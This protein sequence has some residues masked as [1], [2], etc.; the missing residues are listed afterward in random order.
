MCNNNIDDNNDD[1]R[2]DEVA[3][4][5]QLFWQGASA[6]FKHLAAS[7]RA[8]RSLRVVCLMSSKFLYRGLRV[9]GRG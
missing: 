6:H 9:G 7:L 8:P 2:D 3:C 4:V 5:G 1:N